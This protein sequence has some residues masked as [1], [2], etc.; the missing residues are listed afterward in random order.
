MG[1]LKG[2]GDQLKSTRCGE[3][4]QRTERWS[5]HS[6]F[7]PEKDEAAG[8]AVKIGGAGNG[9][10]LAVAEKSA[11]RHRADAGAEQLRVVV[12]LAVKMF[13]AAHAGKKQR[14]AGLVLHGFIASE[15]M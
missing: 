10:D 5:G 9:P 4:V 13:A 7:R 1:S 8:V 6:G 2:H 3:K 12:G 11:E 14:A 15:Q